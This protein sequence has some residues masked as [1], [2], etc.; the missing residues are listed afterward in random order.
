VKKKKIGILSKEWFL[1]DF[2]YN[3]NTKIHM[4]PL[5]K[6]KLKPSTSRGKSKIE[7]FWCHPYDGNSGDRMP[8][9]NPIAVTYCPG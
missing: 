4:S 2:K 7:A 9:L 8:G 1:M 6:L 3:K 5:K